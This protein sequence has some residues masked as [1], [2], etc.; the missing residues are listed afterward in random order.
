[1]NP[2]ALEDCVH[3]VL[4]GRILFVRRFLDRLF[5]EHLQFRLLFGDVDRVRQEQVLQGALV[6]LAERRRNEA[7]LTRWLTHQ[8][9]LLRSYGVEADDYAL[10]TTTLLL[11]LAE[12]EGPAWS[13]EASCACRELLGVLKAIMQ[14][15]AS[16]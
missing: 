14:R 8:A 6:E 9:R 3:R 10:L 13:E 11:T 15:E 2:N 5:R 12:T 4:S 7:D 1:M 16:R